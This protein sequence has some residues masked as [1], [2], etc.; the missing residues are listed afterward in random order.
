MAGI[1]HPLIIA[2]KE[3]KRSFPCRLCGHLYYSETELDRHIKGFHEEKRDGIV[4]I[5]IKNFVKIEISCFMKD[6]V[7][8]LDENMSLLIAFS[9]HHIVS[10][11]IF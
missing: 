11:D 4:N 7:Q 10:N 5:A 6:N 8:V 1:N 2:Y 9:I 3:E